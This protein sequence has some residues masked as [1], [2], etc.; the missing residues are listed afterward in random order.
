[1]I[2]LIVFCILSVL[3]L[4]SILE[5]YKIY[6]KKYIVKQEEIPKNCD[7]I[8]VLGAGIRPDGTP[9]DILKDRL[10][11]AAQIYSRRICKRI[12]LT[13]EHRDEKYSEVISMKNWI[14][15]YIF[16]EDNIILDGK[17]L[18]TYDSLYRAF[19]KFN[20]RK[21]IISTNGYHLPRAIYIARKLGIEAY[22]VASELREY[23]RM[24]KYKKRE[25]LAQ[26]KDFFL[27]NL[28]GKIKR[29]NKLI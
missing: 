12:L 27:V 18:C 9:C 26:I 24:K 7:V 23:D 8:I 5:I 20:I 11:T 1:M 10:F 17:G 25:K 13:G 21:A 22:G 6:G 4:L 14:V 16:Y 19:N 3:F 28:F 2:Y 29:K 15:K